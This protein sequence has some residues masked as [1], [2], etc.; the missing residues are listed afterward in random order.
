MF[1]A[2]N[3]SGLPAADRANP[4]VIDGRPVSAWN[5][6]HNLHDTFVVENHESVNPHYQ[7]ELWRTAGGPPRTSSPPA[8]RC[9]RC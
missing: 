4:A 1:W 8:G 6:A 5:V 9:P 7:A 2:A 3:A